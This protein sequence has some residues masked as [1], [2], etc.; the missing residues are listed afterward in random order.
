MLTSIH[1]SSQAQSA[2]QLLSLPWAVKVPPR[3]TCL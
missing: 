3:T 2:G 1:H